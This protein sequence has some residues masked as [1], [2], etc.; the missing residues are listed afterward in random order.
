MTFISRMM[1]RRRFLTHYR[2]HAGEEM[3]W[4]YDGPPRTYHWPPRKA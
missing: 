3:R 2:R 1:L 4:L